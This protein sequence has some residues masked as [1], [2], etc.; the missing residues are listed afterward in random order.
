[1]TNLKQVSV[2]S[3]E[4]RHYVPLCLNSPPQMTYYSSG[5]K[6]GKQRVHSNPNPGSVQQNPTKSRGKKEIGPKR[7]K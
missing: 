4:P 7:D 1:M 5:L 3:L 2:K 6:T